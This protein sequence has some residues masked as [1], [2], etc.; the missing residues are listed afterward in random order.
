MVSKR[1]ADYTAG[2]GD[3][4]KFR[5]NSRKRGPR[6]R[7]QFRPSHWRGSW[8]PPGRHRRFATDAI[9]FVLSAALLVS[10]AGLWWMWERSPSTPAEAQA[11]TSGPGTFACPSAHVIDGDTLHCGD[12]R[13][14]LQGID[15][16][17]LEGHCRPGRQCAPGDPDASKANLEVLVSGRALQCRRIE[18]DVYGRTIAQCTVDGV[19]LSCRQITGGF[20]IARYAEIF[21]PAAVPGQQS[22]ITE[23]W[24]DGPAE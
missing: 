24:L 12:E 15:A 7:G 22:A 5:R 2:M 14:R 16:P 9:R 8:R 19:D 21:C 20:A 23:E 4:I 13:I 11:L 3:I 6:N 18:T 17:E 10:A 1:F